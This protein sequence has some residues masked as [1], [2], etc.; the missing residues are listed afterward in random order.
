VRTTPK[1]A[2]SWSA[3]ALGL[4]VGFLALARFGMAWPPFND[5][6]PG[7]LLRWISYVGLALLGPI[8]ISA[9]IVAL[10]NPKRGGAILLIAMPFTVFCVA[11]PAAGYLV[12]HSDGSGWFEPP[13]IPT[14]I[15]LAVLFFL[16]VFAALL[17]IRRRKRTVY[18][19]VLTLTLAGIVFGLSHWAKAFLPTFG[20]WSALFLSFGLFWRGTS[21]R[22][23]PPLLQPRSRPLRQRV[24]AITFTCLVVF[25]ADVAVTVGLSAAGSSLFSGDCNVKPLFVRPESPYQAVFTAHVVFVGRSIE[26]LTQD[27]GIFRDPR[28][29]G[30]RDP[31]VGDW[32]IGVVQEKF[33]GLPSWS[34]LVLLTNYIYWKDATYFL[35]GSRGPGL[36]TRVL[37]IVEGRINCSRTK[38][39]QHAIVDLRALHEAPSATGPR[40][41]GYVQEP[42]TTCVRGLAPPPH[43]KFAQGVRISVTGPGGTQIVTTDQSGIYQVDGVSPGDYTLS[44]LIPDNKVA[45]LFERDGSPAKVHLTGKAAV[46]RSFDLFWNGRIEGRVADD[47]GRPVQTLVNLL[48][49][50]GSKSLD[51]A[52][53]VLT[54]VDGCYQ[55][56]RIP[57]G[58][59]KVM[60][61]TTGQQHRWPSEIQFYPSKSRPEDAKVFELSEGQRI[62]GIDFKVSHPAKG[63]VQVGAGSP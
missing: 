39:V 27:R 10:R 9:S 60:I 14:A 29:P 58:R 50:T 34:R 62:A 51:Y 5:D 43:P 15:G 37:P 1:R 61:D 46:D 28:I 38:P 42:E 63:A 33:W 13:G 12:W 44:L 3:V 47:S 56:K 24:I 6:L 55:L 35:D 45:G 2:L 25:C 53:S 48:N 57:P 23:W 41:L 40:I 49:A 19:F 18:L 7:W 31:H 22:N 52:E 4:V 16:P 8:F 11:Y 30:S 17:A 20:G 54:S 32:A 36:L 59:Y 26:A 21:R